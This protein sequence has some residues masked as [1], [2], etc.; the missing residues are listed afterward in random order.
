MAESY[1]ILSTEISMSLFQEAE[2]FI[3]KAAGLQENCF[4]QM[5]VH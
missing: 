5:V 1:Q 3:L 2:S 4:L